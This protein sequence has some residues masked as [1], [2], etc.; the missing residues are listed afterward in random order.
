M[1]LSNYS[2]LKESIIAWSKRDDLDLLV[3]DFINLSEQDMYK[4]AVSVLEIKEMELNATITSSTS[5]EFSSLPTGYISMRGARLDI[6]NSSD[7]IEY[8][9]PEQLLR[10]NDAGRPVFFTIIG[11]QIEFD[12]ISDQ[13]YSMDISYYGKVDALTSS[14]T[15]NSILTNYP[16]IY[17]FGALYY[18][19]I[20]C[21]EDDQ[22]AK[23]RNLFY[24]AIQG[25]NTQSMNGRFGPSPKM[26]VDGPTP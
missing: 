14:N 1:A 16:N 26:T 6:T 15:T 9:T 3:P 17:L 19:S 8:R 25:A 22:A 2:E 10:Q 18:A 24:S 5:T 13:A 7:F 21:E 12:R 20:Y 11:A 4:N 23:Y